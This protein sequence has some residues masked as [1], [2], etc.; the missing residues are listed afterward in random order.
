MADEFENAGMDIH[1]LKSLSASRRG[2]LGSCTRKMNEI[3]A[4]VDANEHVETVKEG[5]DE[6]K[7]ALND[8]KKAHEYVQNLLQEDVK[9][10]ERVDWYEPKMVTFND[11]LHEV[12]V[13]V[14]AHYDPQTSVQ[15]NDSISNV[16]R[17]SVS[18][19]ASKGDI[20]SRVS[21]QYF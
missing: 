13:W 14:N 17:S 4:L 21:S 1:N 16:S 19:R 2:K 3:G 11:F 9:E 7:R 6:F 20:G 18:S 15:P 10:M 5:L 8:F 12:D